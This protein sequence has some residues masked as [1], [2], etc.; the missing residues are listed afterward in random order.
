MLWE[1]E[2]LLELCDLKS[3]IELAMHIAC[4]HE[5]PKSRHGLLHVEDVQPPHV[6]KV[7]YTPGMAMSLKH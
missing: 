4:T 5:V 6:E 7:I 2:I 3:G 1:N